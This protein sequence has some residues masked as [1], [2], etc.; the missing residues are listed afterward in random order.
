MP[1]LFQRAPW[2]LRWLPHHLYLRPLITRYLDA[3]LKGFE[4]YITTGEVVRRNQF[5]S[6]YVFSPRTKRKN[7]AD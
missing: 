3:V 2:P 1:Y 7:D 5:G 6:H 4:V